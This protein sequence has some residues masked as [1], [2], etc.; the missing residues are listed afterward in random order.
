MEEFDNSTMECWNVEALAEIP[1]RREK[2][3][4]VECWNNGALAENPIWWE[5]KDGTPGYR[6]CALRSALCALR[7]AL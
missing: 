5:W 4:R 7:S 6:G 3:G 1:L 2:N